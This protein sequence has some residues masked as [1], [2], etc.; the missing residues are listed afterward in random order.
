MRARMDILNTARAEPARR[1]GLGTDDYDALGLAV[2]LWAGCMSLSAFSITLA[3]VMR[4]DGATAWADA[5]VYVWI[6]TLPVVAVPLSFALYRRALVLAAH[7]LWRRSLI[8]AP[9]I[10]VAAV[11]QGVYDHEAGGVVARLFGEPPLR[12]LFTEV[13]IIN[14]VNYL[15]LYVIYVCAIE[16]GIM[17]AHAQRY[18]RQAARHA[19]H[20]A[21]AREQARE[22]QL[23]LL[24]ARL[25]P[26][27]LFNTLNNVISLVTS[28][29]RDRATLMLR[30]LSIYLRATLDL[31]G[32]A[33]LSL[34][35]EMAAAEAYAEIEA[36]RFDDVLDLDID[37]P[38]ELRQACVPALILLPLVENAVKYAVA[39]SRGR[40][41]IS[42]KAWSSEG[43]LKIEVRDTGLASGV[44]STVPSGTGI[45]LR[46]VADRLL[47]RYGGDAGL[48]A[49]PSERGFAALIRLP[50]PSGA[51]ACVR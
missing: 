28:D 19:L 4:S 42:I 13:L 49:G 41:S 1:W 9:L 50:I 32:G 37:C 29:D 17:R 10:L 11:L 15:G 18:A 14:V 44:A 8:Q 34:E 27:F 39:P 24:W 3:E 40:A 51:D 7:P 16:L 43:V 12:A 35:D 5:W 46:N 20:S 48:E 30:R 21:A 47:A 22:A 26:H 38:P 31:N 25:N 23:E 33:M 45:G 6:L 2:G 36:V